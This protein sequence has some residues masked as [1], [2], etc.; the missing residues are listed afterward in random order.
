MDPYSPGARLVA[1]VLRTAHLFTMAVFVGGVWLAAGDEAVRPW[2]DGAVLSGV[3]LLA[4]EASHSRS[5]LLQVRGL[6]ALLHVASLALLAVGGLDRTATAL[7][8]VVG[9]A[10][11]HAPKAI[12]KWSVRHRAVVD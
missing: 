9:A 12:R 5:W 1:L 7:A 2:R 10:G 8:V 11:S 6:A 3:A 4:T